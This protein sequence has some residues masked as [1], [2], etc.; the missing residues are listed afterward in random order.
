MREFIVEA[1]GGSSG[2]KILPK[3]QSIVDDGH[4]SFSKR[5]GNWKY[6]VDVDGIL[7]I[8]YFSTEVITVDAVNKKII[9]TQ[10]GGYETPSTLSGISGHL[11]TLR[12]L[13]YPSVNA[14]QGH[15]DIK[16]TEEQREKSETDY[17]ENKRL[18]RNENARINRRYKKEQ[19]QRQKEEAIRL[20]AEY[21][22]EYAEYMRLREENKPP[23][24]R[25]EPSEY[26]LR[27]MREGKKLREQYPEE[28][29][30]LS[31]GGTRTPELEDIKKYIEDKK[32]TTWEERW[33]RKSSEPNLDYSKLMK[34]SG[35]KKKA[36][37][38]FEHIEYKGKTYAIDYYEEGGHNM[39]SLTV[40]EV[41]PESGDEIREVYSATDFE[42]VQQLVEDGF[43]DYRKPEEF[44]RYLDSMGAL[45]KPVSDTDKWEE[46]W[47]RRGGLKPIAWNKELSQNEIEE[48]YREYQITYL[49]I[50]PSRK[51]GVVGI[52]FK[53]S[54]DFVDKFTIYDDGTIAFDH[55]MPKIM[56]QEVS[57]Y[58]RNEIAG[59]PKM[60]PEEMFKNRKQ[61]ASVEEEMTVE[62]GDLLL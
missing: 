51:T 48:S 22:E 5:I 1:F 23:H 40:D 56:Y 26:L 50:Y 42:T 37:I 4:L 3:I 18:R 41:D 45:D 19:I 21:P 28:Y 27:D 25:Q 9:S 7:H 15:Y 53:H 32:R 38:D 59:L 57:D 17:Y 14:F 33:Q 55:W 10:T 29:D 62:A 16:E 61:L 43:Y 36:G 60:T 2:E 49:K 44:I 54:K 20:K 39:I 46:R 12:N 35:I 8:T 6:E 30:A 24:Y 11:W 52:D 58:I 34:F 13:G 47:Q 31:Q